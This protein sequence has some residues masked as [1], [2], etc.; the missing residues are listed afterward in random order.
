VSVATLESVDTT[1]FAT[2][3]PIGFHLRA[4]HGMSALPFGTH[5]RG[6]IQWQLHS[7]QFSAI[8]KNINGTCT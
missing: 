1:D 7:L 5:P 2:P 4:I 8:S 6:H 3:V